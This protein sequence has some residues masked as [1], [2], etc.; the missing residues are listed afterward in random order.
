MSGSEPRLTAA[1]HGRREVEPD[2]AHEHALAAHLRASEP[3]EALVALYGRFVDGETPFD[4]M[5]R[6]VLWQSLAKRA[7]SGLRIGRGVRF[8]HIET[9]EIGDGVFVGDQA[10]VQGR[11]DGRC[12]VGDHCWLG[13]QSYFDARQLVLEEY[14]GWGP[15]ARVLGSEHSAMPLDV[16][17][18]QTDVEARPVRIGAGADV[19]VSAVILPGVTVG[20]GAIVGAGA[21]VTRDVPPNAIVAGS[22][23]RVLRYR[24]DAGSPGEQ[25]IDDPVR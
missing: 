17:I 13:P 16:P 21:V 20:R 11:F 24:T 8:M 3:A 5:M 18:I 23:A 14:V 10:V 15:G 2:P 9:F 12:V 19:G 25:G 4:A 22:P 7:G 1:V 6:R